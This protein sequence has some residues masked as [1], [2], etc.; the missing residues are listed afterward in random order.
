MREFFYAG[1]GSSEKKIIL[2]KVHDSILPSIQ[3]R[4]LEL[5]G[6]H[7]G[8]YQGHSYKPREIVLDIGILEISKENL[9]QRVFEIAAW[10]DPQK[11]LRQLILPDTPDKAIDAV[12][13]GT[14]EIERIVT[15]G[16]GSLAF[17]CPDPFFYSIDG[18]HYLFSDMTGGQQLVLNNPG[19]YPEVPVITIRNNEILPENLC[20]NPGFEADTS[21]WVF[22]A[23]GAS[24]GSLTRDTTEKFA[25]AASGRLQK[26]NTTSDIPRCY[27]TITGYQAGKEYP[28]RVR[29][30]SQITNG[31]T[32]YA[33]EK[34]TDWQY[35]QV[36]NTMLSGAAGSWNEITGTVIPTDSGGTVFLFFEAREA[37]SYASWIDEVELLTDEPNIVI[38]PGLQ[39]GDKFLRYNGNLY[40]GDELILDLDRWTAKVNEINVLKD[41][42]GDFF[43]LEPGDNSL[44]FLADAGIAEIETTIYGRWL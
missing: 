4:F 13:T 21:G 14:T 38:R 33:E 2:Q 11:G 5:P 18:Q 28:F 10:L 36:S 34:T 6:R 7:G 16:K 35:P 9:R 24:S 3:S 30:K 37:Q 39:L 40:A 20:P 15:V 27:F 19:T 1:I 41:I 44:I 23:T 8:L 32:V 43:E 26:N 22:Q 29:V 25:G 12:L 17:L 31:L 42:E